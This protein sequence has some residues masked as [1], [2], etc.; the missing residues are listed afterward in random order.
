MTKVCCESYNGLEESLLIDVE[1]E[2][3]KASLLK[4]SGSFGWC[5]N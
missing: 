4:T 5:L 1:E 2:G 3:G